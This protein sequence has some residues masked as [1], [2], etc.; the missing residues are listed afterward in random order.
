MNKSE[1]IKLG[2]IIP[3][4]DDIYMNQYTVNGVLGE[5]HIVE[6]DD[7]IDLFMKIYSRGY[8]EGTENGK[9]RKIDDIKHVLELD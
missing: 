9:Q 8:E 4:S 6:D 1:L 7:E 5:F 2:L 3:V